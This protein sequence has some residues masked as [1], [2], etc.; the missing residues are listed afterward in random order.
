MQV[1]ELR[2]DRH[3]LANQREAEDLWR[4]VAEAVRRKL[5]VG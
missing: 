4:S 3:A 5:A 1:A 2:A